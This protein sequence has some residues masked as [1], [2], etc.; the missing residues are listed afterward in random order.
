M[1]SVSSRFKL[2]SQHTLTYSGRPSDVGEP[3][4]ARR[5]PNLLAMMYANRPC[6]TDR[7]K[8]E[9]ELKSYRCSCDANR[10]RTSEIKHVV[11]DANG[12]A[13]LGRSTDIGPRA[14]RVADHPFVAADRSLR[15]CP[16]IVARGLLPSHAPTF[17]DD[18]EMLITLR[19]DSPNGGT[20]YRPRTRRHDHRSIRVTLGNR[21]INVV[22]S[23][24]R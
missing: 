2:R 15:Q 16:T 24:E 17:G 20:R 3:S 10:L 6:C 19:W 4:G 14:Q 23:E 7:V 11:Q 1:T 12:D 5:L 8:P 21:T 22:R 9:A 13:H 18:P